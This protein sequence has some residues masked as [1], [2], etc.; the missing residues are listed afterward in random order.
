MKFLLALPIFIAIGYIFG[1]GWA[2]AAALFYVI[3]KD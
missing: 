1:P 2:F 3:S